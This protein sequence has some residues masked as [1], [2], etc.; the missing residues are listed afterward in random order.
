MATTRPSSQQ[1]G[2]I[3]QAFNQFNVLTTGASHPG[4]WVV[5]NF[6]T[7]SYCSAYGGSAKVIPSVAN[8]L[9]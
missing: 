5:G 3:A 6:P 1:I 2:A 4:M 7:L 9:P 8:I